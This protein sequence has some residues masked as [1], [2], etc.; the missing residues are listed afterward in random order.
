MLHFK[1]RRLQLV[2]RYFLIFC[3]KSIDCVA[4]QCNAKLSHNNRWTGISSYLILWEKHL[5]QKETDNI[6]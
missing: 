6:N 5:N 1:W 4:N 2:R 3:F